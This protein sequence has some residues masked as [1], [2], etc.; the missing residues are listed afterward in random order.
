MAAEIP[1]YTP[2]PYQE[3]CRQAIEKAGEGK[4]LIVLATGMEKTMVFTH[5]EHMG[6]TLIL[7]HRDELVRQ[8]EKYYKGRKIFSVEKAEEHATYEEIV[9]VSV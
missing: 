4:H 5:L 7:S 3:D 8:S 2:R 6:W 1:I 9:S